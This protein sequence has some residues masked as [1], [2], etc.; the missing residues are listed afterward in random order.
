[1][2]GA[3]PQDVVLKL[4]R[5]INGQA[6]V[7]SLADT[8]DPAVKLHMDSSTYRGIRIWAA[9]V[10][11]IR[12]AGRVRELQLNPTELQCDPQEPQI[13]SLRMRW[14]GIDRRSGTPLPVSDLGHVRYRLEQNRI[15]EIWT[16]R[17]NYTFMFGTRVCSPIGYRL[18][19]ARAIWP[20][21]FGSPRSGDTAGSI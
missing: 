7:A 8:L 13:V 6:P 18:I 17:T 5:V 15:V 3:S 1:M 14:S 4:I 12:S 11:L 2:S 19:Q 21:L 9:W 20:Y 10:H 16:H